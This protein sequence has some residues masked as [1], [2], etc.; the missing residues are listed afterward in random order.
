LID[1]ADQLYRHR[2][3]PNNFGGNRGI[4]LIDGGSVPIQNSNNCANKDLISLFP[5]ADPDYH[6]A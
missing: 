6:N 2:Q 4:T 1:Q 5:E 3:C